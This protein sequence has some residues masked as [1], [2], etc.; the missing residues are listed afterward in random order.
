ML[1]EEIRVLVL[2]EEAEN[3]LRLDIY[4]RFYCVLV[5]DVGIF[6]DGILEFFFFHDSQDFVT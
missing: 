5:E 6:T 3:F 4:I 2:L 1:D